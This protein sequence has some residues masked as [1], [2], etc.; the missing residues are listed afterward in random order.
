VVVSAAG[1]ATAHPTAELTW[2]LI[3]GALRHIPYEVQRL[4]EGHW[5]STVGVCVQGK[6]LGIYA[7]GRIGSLVANV[8]GAFGACVVC[9]GREGSLGRAREAGY[10]VA[11]SRRAFFRPKRHP[12]SPSTAQH[13][14]AQHRHS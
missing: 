1:K 3:L 7:Y 8:G 14:D 4:K 10:E 2:G 11:L 5:Q 13:R 6:T 9:W 12:E